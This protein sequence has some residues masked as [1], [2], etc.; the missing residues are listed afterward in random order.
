MNNEDVLREIYYDPNHPASFSSPERLW[1]LARSRIQGLTLS[2]TKEWLSSQFTC[3]IHR[4]V[5]RRFPRNRVMATRPNEHW[6]A[7]L[8]DM[9]A[10][11]RL[12]DNVRYLLVIIDVFSKVA[13]VF[14][15]L[16][17]SAVEIEKAFVKAI[18]IDTPAN[19]MTDEGTEFVN[20][21]LKTFYKKHNINF[22]VA[23]NKEIKASIVERLNRTIKG[24]LFKY[25]THAGSRRYVDILPKVVNAYNNS[26]HRT[27]K[28]RPV[29]VK[30]ANQSQVFQNTY[31]FRSKREYLISRHVREKRIKDGE[32]VRLTHK[33]NPFDKGFYSNWRDKL[34]KVKS[35]SSSQ[36]PVYRITDTSGN[37]EGKR[38]YKDEIQKVKE[39]EYR[40][41]RIVKRDKRRK[42]VLV[43]WLGYPESANTWEPEANI[44]QLS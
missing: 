38:Y 41:E 32:L 16:N 14:T 2:D 1:K 17:K 9:Q 28:M 26:F 30:E 15:L 22:F 20:V 31:G 37:L 4:Q 10:W 42:L 3:T 43:K 13:Q 7:D 34:Y 35:S 36:R 33:Q 23:R 19:L 5:R 24:R 29:D 27:I 25:M 21:R 6:Q 12:N 40:V 11:S 44:V 39:G 8:V 18:A